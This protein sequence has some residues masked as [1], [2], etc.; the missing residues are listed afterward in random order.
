MRQK[1]FLHNNWTAKLKTDAKSIFPSIPDKSLINSWIPATVPGT[2]HTDLITAKKINDPFIA[3]N[4]KKLKWIHESDWM[5]RTEFDLSKENIS[6]K[7]L[8]LVF[9]GLDTV[10]TVELNGKTVGD[11]NNM[12]RKY[13]FPIS[14]VVKPTGNILQVEF[15]SPIRVGNELINQ[16][17]ELS[18]VRFEERVYLRKA[19][20]SFGWDW[21]PSFPTVGIWRPVYLESLEK[22]WISAVLFDT[23][24]IT[25]TL[26]KVKIRVTL[27]GKLEGEYDIESN[28]TYKHQSIRK[29][30]SIS[31][32]GIVEIEMEVSNPFLW[33]PTGNGDQSLYDLVVVLSHKGNI[34]DQSQRRVGIRKVDLIQEEN[35][36]QVFCFRVNNRSIYMK[37][38]N[39][40]PSDSFIPRIKESTYRS[41]LHMA[42]DCGMN[43]LRVWGGGIYEQPLFYDLCDELGLLIWQ[44][45]MFACSSYPENDFYTENVRQEIREIVTELQ[46][47]PSI[48]IWCG[49]NEN[50]WIWYR[51]QKGPYV[52]MP[53]YK[54][55]HH[56]LP[57]IVHDLDPQRPYW[58][59][60]PF[61][62]EEDPN[63]TT[64]GN[65]HSWD[66]WSRWIDYQEVEKDESL[67]VSE[68]G[69]QGPAN[70]HTLNRVL[71]KENRRIQ[72]EI[73]EFHNKQDEGNE[74]LFRF[75]AGHLPVNTNWEDFI[76]LTQLN[77][78]LALKTCLEHW[79]RRWPDTAGSLIWQLNDCWP[80]TSWSLID[81]QLNP[82]LA[83]YFVRAV[84]SKK[85]IFIKKIGNQIVTEIMND[86]SED[87]EGNIEYGLFDLLHN[88]VLNKHNK[89]IVVRSRER[90]TGKSLSLAGH[91]DSGNWIF[92]TTLFDKQH[93]IV[94]RNYYT[95]KKWK[96]LKTKPSNVKII[97]NE[98][99][100][101]ALMS[102]NI[103]LFVDLYHKAA[104]FSD[105]G[106]I[107]LPGEKKGLDIVSGGL[108]LID[109]DDIKIF[110]LNDYLNKVG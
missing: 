85:S 110:T 70:I 25:D 73:F 13:R 91:L 35:K 33:W 94:N 64:S 27:D 31:K 49:N 108:K 101:I 88:Q 57:K 29:V 68:F 20:Y 7:E 59:T 45:F 50:E 54:I 96:Y 92:I 21:G 48:A 62:S 107:I 105:K 80:V 52:K 84:F 14:E 6:Q 39:W 86:S 28:L 99:N 95:L 71:K 81:S 72:D 10:A 83:Y 75:L 46:H 17:G 38:A 40:I 66:I 15:H 109:V 11:T 24:E 26:A 5:Y 63:A 100:K 93:H 4:E 34:I 32:T 77:Q 8:Y 47:H 53:G 69:F 22:V 9:D 43:M 55:F 104:R 2:I 65:R 16:F 79:Y 30:R 23:V 37:G 90:V 19:Q 74:R 76:Y 98:E 78:G 1:W 89:P 44:D 106:F 87:F 97:R 51:E 36:K 3:D 82:K 12:F 61:G 41:L 56:E 102:E 60:T 67:F 18:S 103:A 58:P 42:K